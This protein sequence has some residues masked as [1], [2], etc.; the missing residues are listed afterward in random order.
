LGIDGVAFAPYKFFGV[1]GSGIGYVSERLSVLPHPKLLGKDMTWTL[2][3][4]AP[5]HYA[6][7][8]EVV[9]Y[10]CWIG[11]QYISSTDRRTL[12]MEGMNRIKLHERALMNRMLNGSEG[13][14]GLR[15]MAGVKVYLDHE[16]MTS[17]DFIIAVALNN[18]G[19]SE[20]VREYE[21]RGVI[22]FER[23]SSSIY[24][25]RMLE[26]F[27]IDGAIRISPLHCNNFD[28][29]DEFLKITME[30]TQRSV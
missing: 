18:W 16:D 22:V 27:G 20:A 7:I 3:S 11:S 8:S 5:S 13:I 26:S 17:R 1:R 21:R 30:M 24:S 6:V 29:I 15:R 4:P 25:K 23:L 14:Q 10:V 9:D 12:F 2:G 28:E 19:Y